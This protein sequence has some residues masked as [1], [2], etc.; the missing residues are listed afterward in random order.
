MNTTPP[1]V[2]PAITPADTEAR[3]ELV[4]DG[5][6]TPRNILSKNA[7]MPA[8]DSHSAAESA[9]VLKDIPWAAKKICS[10]PGGVGKVAENTMAMGTYRT[11][12]EPNVEGMKIV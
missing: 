9:M 8:T 12:L 11:L 10:E 7:G 4:L 6:A 5:E 2:A 1:T 3:G